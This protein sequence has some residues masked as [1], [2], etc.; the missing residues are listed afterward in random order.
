[1]KINEPQE[2]NIDAVNSANNL[3]SAITA[4]KIFLRAV[5]DIKQRGQL[6]D[7]S[8][9]NAEQTKTQERSMKAAVQAFNA[10]TKQNLTQEQGWQFISLIIILFLPLT[11]VYKM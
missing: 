3:N 2:T 4:N 10:L 11:G 1:M 9:A 8:L 6:R 7:R 5:N